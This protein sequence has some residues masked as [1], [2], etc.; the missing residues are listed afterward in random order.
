VEVCKKTQ[1]RFLVAT[2]LLGT[3]ILTLLGKQIFF[4]HDARIFLFGGVCKLKLSNTSAKDAPA[5]IQLILLLLLLLLLLG[6]RTPI[7]FHYL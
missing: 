2:T 7:I 1:F 4:F 3:P 6:S 5:L